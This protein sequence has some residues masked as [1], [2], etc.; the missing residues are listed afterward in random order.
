MHYCLYFRIVCGACQD[1]WGQC[2]PSQHVHFM[3]QFEQ[4]ILEKLGVKKL[5][6]NASASIFLQTMPRQQHESPARPHYGRSFQ[7]NIYLVAWI[8]F[9]DISYCLVLIIILTLV[10]FRISFGCIPVLVQCTNMPENILAN[11]NSV[12]AHSLLLAVNDQAR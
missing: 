8:H 7:W 12:K 4:W 2:F 10:D 3:D 5:N 1:R 9:C 11:K 6:P